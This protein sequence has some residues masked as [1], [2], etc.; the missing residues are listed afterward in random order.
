LH[1]IDEGRYLDNFLAYLGWLDR[2]GALLIRSKKLPKVSKAE[3]YPDA[4]I[5]SQVNQV[6][7]LY[8]V[9]RRAVHYVDRE[10]NDPTGLELVKRLQRFK[11]YIFGLAE[12]VLQPLQLERLRALI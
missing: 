3:D 2:L 5:A 11:L 6:F 10:P 12:C 1:T 4:I 8:A 9:A 7:E